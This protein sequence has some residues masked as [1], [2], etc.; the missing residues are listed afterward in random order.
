MRPHRV[1]AP[2]LCVALSAGWLAGVQAA[3]PSAAPLAEPSAA[4]L[5][6]PRVW[7]SGPFGRVLG[8]DPSSPAAAA[9]D[10]AA[11]DT[12]LPAA[13]L[14]LE[15]AWA[16]GDA[17]L[18]HPAEDDLPG[19]A[20]V[21]RSLEEGA[22]EVT[23]SDGETSFAGPATPGTSVIVA[24]IRL[25]GGGSSEHAWLVEVPD[26]EGGPETLLEMPGPQAVLSS[27]AGSVLGE[28]GDGCYLYLCVTAGHAPPPSALDALPL[29]VGEAPQLRLD[30]GSAMV[31]WQA[32][33]ATPGERPRP[34]IEAAGTFTEAPAADL[35]LS[36][37]EPPTA[38]EWLLELRVEYDRER[39]W[40][41]FHFRLAAR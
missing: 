40:Q 17:P 1:A 26:R 39:G 34:R 38:G 20:V 30:D 5:E 3:E 2:L 24:R 25:A 31:A 16:E 13:P 27:T 35:A 11:L 19:L 15:I 41:W 23:L 14:Q 37:L 21:W 12:W 33:L 36:G 18:D 32:T 6:E 10:G 4:P 8:T 9:P 29:D 22:P 7:L 28:P